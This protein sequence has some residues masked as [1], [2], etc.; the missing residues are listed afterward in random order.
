ME[1]VGSGAL[2]RCETHTHQGQRGEKS[3]SAPMSLWGYEQ[4]HRCCDFEQQGGD[5]GINQIIRTVFL[6]LIMEQ[7]TE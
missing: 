4:P 3:E 6:T 2:F 7:Q 5:A 1:K